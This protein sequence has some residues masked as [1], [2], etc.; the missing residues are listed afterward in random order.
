MF[1][2]ENNFKNFNELWIRKHSKKANSQVE[3]DSFSNSYQHYYLW[4]LLVAILLF[5]LIIHK[6]S[7]YLLRVT[8]L[9][10]TSAY[11]QVAALPNYL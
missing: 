9:P 5:I 2:G 10:K 4:I 6:L 8:I 11:N 3:S 7:Q 1:A